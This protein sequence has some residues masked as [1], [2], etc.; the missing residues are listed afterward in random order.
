MNRNATNRRRD[1][2]I[3]PYLFRVAYESRAASAEDAT[4]VTMVQMIMERVRV[5]ELRPPPYVGGYSG[6]NA[7]GRL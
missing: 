6:G 2:G 4:G 5:A 1:R 7:G 3:G